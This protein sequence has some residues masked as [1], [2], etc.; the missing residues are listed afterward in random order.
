MAAE[1]YNIWDLRKQARRRVPRVLFDFV[2]RGAEDDVATAV[3]RAALDRLKL[4]PRVAIDVSRRSSTTTL[5]GKALGLPIAIAPT[6]AA[7][8]MWY[9]GELSL[10]KAAAKAKIPFTLATSSTTSI[11]SVADCAGA[12]FWLQLYL[13]DQRELSYQVIDRAKQAGA[14]ALVV[15]LDTPV[16][17]NREFNDRNGFSNP[18]RVTPRIAVDLA[19]H[20]RW[21][22]GVMGRYLMTGGM[23]R[24]VNYPEA[25][26]GRITGGP[27]RRANSASV[28]WDDIRIL[29]DRWPRTLIVKGLLRP[30]DALTAA[31]CGV[32]AVVVSNHG[33]RM[34]DA[35][36]AS[37][38]ALPG[39]VAA[40]GKRVTVL[41]D[42]GIRRG[43]DIVKALALG[44][45][46]VLVGR[47]TLYGLAAGGQPG[48]E[49]S[50]QILAEETDRTLGLIGCRVI[51]DLDPTF[52]SRLPE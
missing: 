52:V 17:P 49:R 1:A 43:T 41:F 11:E 51:A 10:A 20:P 31:S 12:G 42:G 13:W 8:L 45:K 21:L 5:F 15:T 44:A 7:D 30:E 26:G 16:A 9:E 39:V 24:F 35:A 40:A 36:P 48:V 34:L 14:D 2:D 38:D 25:M 4:T 37:I 22:L 23:P 27:R 6:G 18:F 46:A 29:R 33:G 19:L 50:L 32:D 28:T 47:A 3:N